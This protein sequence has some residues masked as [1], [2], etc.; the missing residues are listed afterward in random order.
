MAVTTVDGMP[1]GRSVGSRVRTC[2][3][4][5]SAA[6]VATP[7]RPWQ[8][9]G[10]P[11]TTVRRQPL[12]LAARHRGPRAACQTPT[13]RG[14]GPPVAAHIPH[15]LPVVSGGLLSSSAV[16]LV[17][18]YHESVESMRAVQHEMAHTAPPCR[19]SNF[20]RRS[21]S[22]SGRRPTPRTPS[23][24]GSRRPTGSTCS[25]CC[26]WPRRSHT[27]RRGHHGTR[28]L[29]SV[30]GTRWSCRRNWRTVRGRGRSSRRARAQAFFGPVYFVRQ[31]EPYMRMAVPIERGRRGRSS[32]SSWPR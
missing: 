17:F 2:T 31:S 16:E 20:S 11:R 10:D 15:R 4:A 21:H 27:P 14:Q 1:R 3:G 8:Y 23:R 13:N 22:T 6:G 18:R 24:P 29:Q 7:C 19:S 30:A 26:I 28:A 25:S 5:R 12:C 9:P 32:A